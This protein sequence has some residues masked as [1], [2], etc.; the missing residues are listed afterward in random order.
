[1]RNAFGESQR[2][3]LLGGT[4]D[5]G[6]AAIEAMDVP[7]LEVLL[8]GRP[9]AG[10]EAA[11]QRLTAAP[12]IGSVSVL[13]FDARAMDAHQSVIDQAFAAGDVDAVILAFGVLGDQER[14]ERD[15]DAAVQVAQINYV[16]AMSMGLRVAAK[17]QDQGSGVLVVL[18]SVAGERARKSNF[19]YGSTKA[20]L[21]AFAMG[22]GDS[23]VGTGVRVV[24]V[25]PGFV[26]TSMTEHLEEAP[27]AVDAIDVGRAIA[28]ALAHPR[29]E[30]V[31]VP[32]TMRP[33]M[34]ALRHIPRKAFRRLPI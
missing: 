19:I 15:P 7:D 24:V 31:Y 14:D 33:V 20:G 28:A 25:R 11:V 6:L 3:L 30:V 12:N 4:S 1:M 13:E 21:D 27:L 9:G 16:A 17:L 32:A 2:V 8:A 23:L 5:I 26:R 18:S 29:R 10:L 22:L 34:S